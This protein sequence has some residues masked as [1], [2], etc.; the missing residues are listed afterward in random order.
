VLALAMCFLEPKHV[1]HGTWEWPR[2]NVLNA[3]ESELVQLSGASSVFR[4]SVR[5]RY[6]DRETARSVVGQ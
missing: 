2:S 1:C 5:G 3:A 4:L 6:L